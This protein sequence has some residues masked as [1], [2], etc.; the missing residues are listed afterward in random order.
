MGG[1]RLI[2]LGGGVLLIAVFLLVGGIDGK[3]EGLQIKESG[4]EFITTPLLYISGGSI[5]SELR[6]REGLLD[7]SIRRGNNFLWPNGLFATVSK[8][9]NH[10]ERVV[11]WVVADNN[12][13]VLGMKTSHGAMGPDGLYAYVQKGSGFDTILVESGIRGEPVARK[14]YSACCLNFDERGNLAFSFKASEGAPWRSAVWFQGLD[15]KQEPV[16]VPEADGVIDALFPS[17]GPEGREL[18]FSGRH[19]S[20]GTGSDRWDL[21]VWRLNHLGSGKP[22]QLTMEGTIIDPD[23]GPDGLIAVTRLEQGIELPDNLVLEGNMESRIYVIDLRDSDNPRWLP[24]AQGQQPSWFRV[25]WLPRN[26]LLEPAPATPE[27]TAEAPI[28]SCEGVSLQVVM[29]LDVS[30]SM[31]GNPIKQEKRGAASVVGSLRPVD[32]GKVIAY[33]D[34]MK[35]S[36][37]IN[38]RDPAAL[39]DKFESWLVD[40]GGD[41]ALYDAL[42][43]GLEAFDGVESGSTV[44]RLLIIFTDGEDNA[45]QD[46]MEGLAPRHAEYS[47][48]EDEVLETLVRKAVDAGVVI[49]A[50]GFHG[51]VYSG[52]PSYRPE[53]LNFLAGKTAGTYRETEDEDEIAALIAEVAAEEMCI[54][55]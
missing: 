7:K 5:Y 45:S 41:T 28:T 12:T 26:P 50:V 24:V 34:E 29:V 23:W 49:H 53:P 3:Q 30:G 54:Q 51:K 8:R 2:I 21:W 33:D 52:E 47:A 37:W 6:V 25:S 31:E 20:Q 36:G 44:R 27:P 46:L 39:Q 9:T 1:K 48:K 11:N 15:Y 43:M 18:V 38:G 32:I 40:G 17:I 22:T 19:K 4:E 13:P 55:R 14:Y 42:N 16:M 10:A 35:Q